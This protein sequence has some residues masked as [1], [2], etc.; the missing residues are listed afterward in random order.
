MINRAAVILKY[1]DPAIRWIN[2]ADP[3][4]DDPGITAESVN[5]E[6]TVYLI[7]DSDGDSK[8]TLGKWLKKNY[9]AI[10]EEELAGWYDDPTL[11]PGNRTLSLFHQ[12]FEIDC[13]T[14]LIDTVGVQIHDDDT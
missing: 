13:H 12:W 1:K 3:Y 8:E 11:W 2:E 4:D 14:V 5:Q 6:R 7:S 10:F 9:R